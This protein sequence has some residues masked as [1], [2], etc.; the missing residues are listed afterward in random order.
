M[1]IPMQARAF[2]FNSFPHAPRKPRSPLL[3]ILFGLVGLA[4][5]TLLVFFGV[6]VGAA[7]LA[8]GLAWRMVRRREVR[9]GLHP[10][11]DDE[12]IVD[13]EYRVIDR[14]RLPAPR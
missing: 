14:P 7:M 2:R 1:S 12:R 11:G 6:F 10:Q 9:P 13:A 5:L 3:R 8:A 4:L